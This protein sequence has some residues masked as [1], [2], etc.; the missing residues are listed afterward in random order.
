MYEVSRALYREVRPFL[1]PE[2]R[3]KALRECENMI[4]LL[5]RGLAPR[6]AERELFRAIRIDVDLHGQLAVRRAIDRHLAVVRI[7]CERRA[8]AGLDGFGRRLPC[9]A[10]TKQGR[11][12]ERPPDAS[13]YC[14]SHR[15]LAEV[16]A[17]Q[18]FAAA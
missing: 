2:A 15:H 12:C 4:D 17:T 5:A 16:V 14:P 18:A 13:G 7:V 6:R 11:P 1:P 3:A 10:H 8:A 9:A